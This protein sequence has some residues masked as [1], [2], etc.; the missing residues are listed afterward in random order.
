MPKETSQDTWQVPQL[1]EGLQ[2]APALYSYPLLFLEAVCDG[3]SVS[4]QYLVPL[5]R[6][7]KMAL[8]PLSDLYIIGLDLC[9]GYFFLSGY[10]KRFDYQYLLDW[11]R[12]CCR[13]RQLIKSDIGN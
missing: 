1:Y 13:L 11:T 12:C 7:N 5:N 2:K 9:L 3:Q 4:R 8:I 10:W 6:A